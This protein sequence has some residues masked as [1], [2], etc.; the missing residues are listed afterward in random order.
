MVAAT[1]SL[2]QVEIGGHGVKIT[3]EL[4]VALTSVCKSGLPGKFLSK[5]LLISRP[6]TRKSKII[7][8]EL[9]QDIN[10]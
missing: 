10:F 9:G 8:L 1:A 2:A 6:T 3:E 7:G 4:R 5:T